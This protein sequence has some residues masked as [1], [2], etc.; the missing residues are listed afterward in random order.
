MTK[1]IL[2]IS[3]R[4]AYTIEAVYIFEMISP[5]LILLEQEGEAVAKVVSV[6]RS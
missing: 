3:L 1:Y 5:W 4:F 2:F 6:F